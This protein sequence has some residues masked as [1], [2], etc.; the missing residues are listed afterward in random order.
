MD[1]GLKILAAILY[2]SETVSEK[3]WSYFTELNYLISGRP[4]QLLNTN[5]NVNLSDEKKLL[6]DQNS[7]GWAAEYINE[8]IPIFQNYIQK[9]R[10]VIFSVKDP[11]FGLSYI[12]L[13]FKSIDR[14]FQICFNGQSD[15][16]MVIASILYVTVLENYPKQVD[17]ILTYILDKMITI[18]PKAKSSMMRKMVIQIVGMALWYDPKLTLQFLDSKQ[19]TEYVFKGWIELLPE[20]T[21][22]F[23]LRRILIGFSSLIRVNIS[24]LP[25]LVLNSLPQLLHEMINLTSKIL[26][27]RENEVSDNSEAEEDNEEEYNKTVKKLENFNKKQTTSNNDEDDDDY[28]DDDDGDYE[29]LDYANSNPLYDSPLQDL[30]EVLYFKESLELLQQH[31]AY[32]Y[33]Q[34]V[35]ELSEDDKA[36]IQK[37]FETAYQQEADYQKSKQEELERKTKKG[38]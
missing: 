7:E 6:L 32:A 8:M 21:V 28:E 15:V 4:E 14:V 26:N 37:N 29:G 18:L 22:D 1:E 38:L 35:A 31:Q 30:C 25:T 13:L 34:L 10:N 17:D 36:T 24:E 16:D 12:E 2:G 3:M 20:F 27:Q 33:A 23:E 19:A 11:Y 5:N 9:G